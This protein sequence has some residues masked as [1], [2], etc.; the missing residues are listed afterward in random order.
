MAEAIT[1]GQESVG[2]GEFE[3]VLGPRQ[4]ASLGL[5]VLTVLAGCTTAAYV[6]GKNT[7]KVVEVRVPFVPPI[8]A[9]EAP[10]EQRRVAMKPEAPLEGLPEDGKPYIQLGSVERGVAM[11]MT[12]GLRKRGIPS[13]MAPGVSPTV[14]RVLA[15]PF[16]NQDE[17][18][19]VE[20]EFAEA[21]LKTFVRRYPEPAA[22]RP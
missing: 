21:G 14:F 4:F 18:K 9:P 15:G 16:E 7:G 22:A 3:L 13:L 5:V 11:L 1:T 6:V 8:S 17:L 19:K 12:Q 10:T 20:A 2:A